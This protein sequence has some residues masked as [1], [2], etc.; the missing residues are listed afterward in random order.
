MGVPAACTAPDLVRPDTSVC[1]CCCRWFGSWL[2]SGGS[3][4]DTSDCIDAL[5]EASA[6]NH[7]NLN[8]L[9][10]LALGNS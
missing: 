3:H 1:K 8:A 6:T 4:S 5:L 10:G 2:T 7:C 9:G